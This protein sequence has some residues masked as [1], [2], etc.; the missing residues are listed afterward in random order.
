MV[1]YYGDIGG[2][3]EGGNLCFIT[4]NL[5]YPHATYHSKGI[6]CWPYLYRCPRGGGGGGGEGDGEGGALPL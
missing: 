5:L 2:G 3:G 6:L 4:D 1:S